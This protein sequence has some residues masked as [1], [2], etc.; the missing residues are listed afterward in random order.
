MVHDFTTC[1]PVTHGLP[2]IV[3][4]FNVLLAMA[5]VKVT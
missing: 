5:K 4:G 2:V 1:L 3:L